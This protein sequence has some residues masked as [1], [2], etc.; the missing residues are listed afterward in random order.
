MPQFIPGLKLSELFYIEVVKP[1]LESEFPNLKYSA[2]LIDSGSEVL[3]Y[4]TLQSTDHNWGPRMLLFLSE[5]DYMRNKDKLWT[6]LSKSLPYNFKGYPT[7]F[8][9][10][11]QFDV[12]LLEEIKK[13][14]V[15]H[16][17]EVF[18]MRSFFKEYLN[19]DPYS[20]PQTSDWLRFPAHK[21][22]TI[23][24]GKIFHDDLNLDKIRK[25]LNYY[26]KDIWLH[27]LSLQWYR[28]SQEEPF[29]GRCGDVGDELGSKIIASRLINHL[30]KLCFLMEKKYTPYSKWFGTAFAELK[31]SQKLIP[32]FNMVL[33]TQSWKEREKHLSQAYT[34]VAR[35]HNNLSITKSMKT[36]VSKFHNRSYLIIHAK[37]FSDE[38]RKSIMNKKIRELQLDNID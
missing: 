16:R 24:V 4:D 25:K 6:V 35:L 9:K 26:P 23:T 27:F 32:I 30:M 15:N 19:F 18:T 14:P 33:N 22:L 36:G 29:M 5:N 10:P 3:G 12:Q 8:G 11:D 28:I 38:I 20:E 17:V 1:I 37:C 7:N 21:L 34:E 31:S 13:G 2:G